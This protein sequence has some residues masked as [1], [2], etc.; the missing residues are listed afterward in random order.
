MVA[1]WS[2]VQERQKQDEHDTTADVDVFDT[3]EE[4]AESRHKFKQDIHGVLH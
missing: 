2:R 4:V 1:I 3:K